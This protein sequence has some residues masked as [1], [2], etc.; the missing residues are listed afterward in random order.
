MKH[1]SGHHSLKSTVPL[2]KITKLAFLTASFALAPATSKAGQ[3]GNFIYSDDGTSITITG[4]NVVGTKPIV[5]PA[6]IDGKPVR[7]IGSWAF[8][9]SHIAGVI[10]PSGVTSIGDWAFAYA[11]NLITVTFPPSVTRIGDYAFAGVENYE[12]GSPVLFSPAMLR[13]SD[14]SRSRMLFRASRFS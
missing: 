13:L 11:D 12:R 4:N 6:I 7:A 10:I 14:A 8:F 5:I 9:G 1:A 2:S 3:I